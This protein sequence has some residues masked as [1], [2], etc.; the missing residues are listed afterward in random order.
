[1]LPEAKLLTK[2]RANLLLVYA[3]WTRHPHRDRLIVLP[4][5]KAGL[6]AGEIAELTWDTVLGGDGDLAACIEL[7]DHA[8]KKRSG[9]RIPLHPDLREALSAW[10]T[11]SVPAG[12][13]VT[14]ER[15]GPMRASSIVLWFARVSGDRP[16][17]LLIALGAAD[18]HHPG[19]APG[20]QGGWLAARRAAARGPRF[21]HHHPT[22][23]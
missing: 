14:S 8:A 3:G 6:R 22:L 5:V 15:G 19:G 1:V 7:R 21:D 11:V 2:Y 4:S 16:S 17:R 18:L 10:R 9:R 23:H 20:P 13:I 12:P